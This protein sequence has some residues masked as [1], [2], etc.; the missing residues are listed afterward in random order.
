MKQSMISFILFSIPLFVGCG[1]SESNSELRALNSKLVHAVGRFND[2]ETKF[3]PATNYDELIKSAHWIDQM[4]DAYQDIE[5]IERKATA[6]GSS[7]VASLKADLQNRFRK[8]AAS[9]Q[10]SAKYIG[11]MSELERA[12]IWLNALN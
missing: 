5:L 12:Q 7:P 11:A 10:S 2:A 8:H 6:L 4:V 3:G 9:F 1:S